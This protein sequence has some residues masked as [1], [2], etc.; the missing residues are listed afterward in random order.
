MPRQNL[1]PRRPGPRRPWTEVHVY[2]CAVATRL[3]PG[4]IR[5]SRSDRMMVGVG[6]NPR[7]TA[8]STMARIAD[9]RCAAASDV[10]THDRLRVPPRLG[11][12]P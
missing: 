4:T 9:D 10:S 7:P 5:A 8:D 3:G 11:I 12:K 2:T 1:C 6:F